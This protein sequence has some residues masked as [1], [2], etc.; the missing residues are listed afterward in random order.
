M[1]FNN[2]W[3]I[4]VQNTHGVIFQFVDTKTAI[5]DDIQTSMINTSSTNSVRN[6]LQQGFDNLHK[7]TFI[8]VKKGLS[9]K[10]PQVMLIMDTL[11]YSSVF[12]MPNLLCLSLPREKTLSHAYLHLFDFIY[13]DH[14]LPCDDTGDARIN[15]YDRVYIYNT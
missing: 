9:F 15:K 14:N 4:G 1:K 3:K 5:P 11:S 7:F 6:I 2:I 13:A 8:P 12:K 10:I